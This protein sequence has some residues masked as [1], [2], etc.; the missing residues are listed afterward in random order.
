M[1]K[2]ITGLLLICS[3]IFLIACGS[4]KESA[5][6]LPVVKTPLTR[7]ESLLHTVVQLSI[8]HENQEE[9]M[10]GAIKL[11]KEM[12]SLLSTSVE[13]SDIYRINQAA[14]KEPVKVDE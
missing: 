7:T 9:A 11:I 5:S 12:E 2:G 14:G 4:K 8:Y 10:D 3:I 6:Q 13:G 1:K